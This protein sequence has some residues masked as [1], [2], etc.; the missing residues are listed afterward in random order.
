M[1]KKKKN[2]KN[3]TAKK[4]TRAEV[5]RAQAAW[6]AGI[7]KIA[8]A[9][10]AGK[11]YE[12]VARKLLAELYGYGHGDVLFKPTLAA[13]EQFRPTLA[14]ALSYFVATN[15]E[16]YEDKGFAIKGW[17]RVEFP[18]PQ[19]LITSETSALAMGNYV[20]T[21]PGEQQTVEYSFGYKLDDEGALR[22]HLHHSS[23]PYDPE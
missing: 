4:I 12:A 5:K 17:T 18:D 21:K 15:G 8:K 11:D 7:V 6:G 20:F 9:H 23:L 2:A 13:K 16:C 1:G 22:I 19:I 3:K 14:K 10:R